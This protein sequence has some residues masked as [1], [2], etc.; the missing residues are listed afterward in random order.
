MARQLM[1]QADLRVDVTL[2]RQAPTYA[3]LLPG[4]TGVS[5]SLHIGPSL[6][7][8]ATNPRLKPNA[9]GHDR[10]A[11]ESCDQILN[12]APGRLFQG[13]DVHMLAR[14]GPRTR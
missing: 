10:E 8:P 1:S 6:R 5:T 12:R 13:T 9:L 14:V 11:F 2:T 3:T 7:P 4:S